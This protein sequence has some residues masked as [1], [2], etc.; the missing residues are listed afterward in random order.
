MENEMKHENDGSNTNKDSKPAFTKNN[1]T[2][3]PTAVETEAF[4]NAE[5]LEITLKIKEKYPELS[6]YI[7]EMS[8]TIPNV[9]DPEITRKNLK[10][11][12]ESL[13]D[14]LNKYIKE[15]PEN[16]M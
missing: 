5:I 9:Q 3:T 10:V 4:L 12:Y 14:L 8:V 7:E 15:H 13:K 2:T 11:Y 1:P 16:L 6:K